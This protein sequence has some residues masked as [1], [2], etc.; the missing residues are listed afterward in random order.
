MIR[1]LKDASPKTVHVIGGNTDRALITGQRRADKVENAEDWAKFAEK[2]RWLTSCYT[3]VIER[4][5]W[6]DAEFLAKTL[7]RELDLEIPGYGWAIGFHGAPGNDEF[8]MLPDTPADVLLDA[9]IDSEGRI[10]FCGH[11]HNAMDRDLGRWRVVNVGSVGL[12]NDD[13]R[14]TYA[15][16]TFENG[17]A[18]VDLRRVPFDSEAVIRDM[19]R[20]QHPDVEWVAKVLRTGKAE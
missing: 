20:L 7:R 18:T 10:A 4:L 5:P 15:L 1:A 17:T 2:L 16:V 8:S 6:P 12:P 11:T 14:A 3:W 9:L 19:E 13:R